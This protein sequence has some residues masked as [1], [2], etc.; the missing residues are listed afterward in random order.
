MLKQF[1]ADLHIHT[2]LSPCGDLKMTPQKIIQH[3][4][5]QKLDIIA[6]CDHNSA[7]N[8]PAIIKIAGGK[9]ISVISGM[10][11]CTKEEIHILAFF[12][13]M[14]QAFAIQSLVYDNLKGSN[15]PDIFGL[16][17]V[18]NEQDE[19]VGFNNRLLIGA[20]DLSIEEIVNQIHQ[21]NGLAIASHI[22]RES[23]SVIGHL[24]FIPESLKFD[25]L[26][27]SPHL[28]TAEARLQFSEYKNYSFVQSSDAHFIEDV[29]SSVTNFLLDSPSL[30][31]IAKAFKK[32]DGRKVIE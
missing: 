4:L 11:I 8:L 27:I 10:E 31:E 23:Y 18:G 15:N 22:D 1:R 5:E 26:E 28:G 7:E 3:A 14:Q 19:V 25:A 21:F 9:N 20:V 16:Q 32:E 2:C 13:T 30:S 29:G 24:G 6:I 17:V 12:E